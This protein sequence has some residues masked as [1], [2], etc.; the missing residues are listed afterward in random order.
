MVI[1][2]IKAPPVWETDDIIGS[3]NNRTP[4]GL[5]V[6]ERVPSNCSLEYL[7]DRIRANQLRGSMN[8]LSMVDCV[9]EKLSR[10]RGRCDDIQTM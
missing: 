8:R 6:C 7:H 10:V 9:D 4:D 5:H 1:G 3:I 2:E